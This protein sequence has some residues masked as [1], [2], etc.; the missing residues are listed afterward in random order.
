MN[1]MQ[2]KPKFCDRRWTT[3]RLNK[4]EEDQ[5]EDEGSEGLSDVKREE[6]MKESLMDEQE[7][8]HTEKET[9]HGE[10]D[11]VM[12]KRGVV[13]IAVPADD[14]FAYALVSW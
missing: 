13:G 3:E 14:G 12:E 9:Y 8:S 1:C 6:R 7:M 11:W 10:T 4:W 2:L 5:E